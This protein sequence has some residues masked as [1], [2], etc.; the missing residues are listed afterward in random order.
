MRTG[1]TVVRLEWLILHRPD[2]TSQGEEHIRTLM[3]MLDLVHCPAV[4]A[5]VLD[6]PARQ[7]PVDAGANLEGQRTPFTDES[8]HVRYD[9]LPKTILAE[10]K[11][12][13]IRV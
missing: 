1:L 12:P 6:T 3:E 5:E 10:P 11:G 4:T 9:S 13:L 8:C 2:R 7:I